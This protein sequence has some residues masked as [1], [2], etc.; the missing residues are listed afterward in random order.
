MGYIR[1]KPL[2]VRILNGSDGRSFVSPWS[3]LRLR[4]YL[5]LWVTFSR[6]HEQDSATPV[7]SPMAVSTSSPTWASY[8]L[9]IRRPA[10]DANQLHL[11][12]RQAGPRARL[13]AQVRSTGWVRTRSARHPGR[14]LYGAHGRHGVLRRGGSSPELL[15]R[16]WHHE[17]LLRQQGRHGRLPCGRRFPGSART[18]RADHNPR[19]LRFGV[20]A[21]DFRYRCTRRASGVTHHPKARPF[22][23]WPAPS[24][25][26]RVSWVPATGAS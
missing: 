19:Y 12:V 14:L 26:R 3:R 22:R 1:P 20:V 8:D 7:P 5:L 2:P 15:R 6:D 25:K 4:R 16:Q 11:P 21:V 24:S 10:R 18:R 23:S 13:R 9:R 17:R